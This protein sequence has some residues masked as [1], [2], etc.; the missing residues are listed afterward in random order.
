MSYEVLFPLSFSI[1]VFEKNENVT[2]PF[3]RIDSMELMF[4]KHQDAGFL[5]LGDHLTNFL[6]WIFYW[7]SLEWW[8][9][10]GF[11]KNNLNFLWSFSSAFLLLSSPFVG[12]C[13]RNTSH[14]LHIILKIYSDLFTLLS[15][16]FRDA[17]NMHF[18]WIW[19]LS[20]GLRSVQLVRK[21]LLFHSAPA[22]K[23]DLTEKTQIPKPQLYLL[24]MIFLWE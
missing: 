19:F 15:S 11:L 8:I 12:Q 17:K 7:L 22:N 14:I 18:L 3:F 9:F 21:Q 1:S 6:L 2:E 23:T 4:C 13:N 16:K 24:K 5:Q 20:K 10:L